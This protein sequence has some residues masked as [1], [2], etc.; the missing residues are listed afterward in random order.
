MKKNTL[1]TTIALIKGYEESLYLFILYYLCKNSTSEII[2][3][4]W[5]L[6]NNKSFQYF[7]A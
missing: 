4:G 3:H 5:L 6:Q 2:I 7:E 1:V